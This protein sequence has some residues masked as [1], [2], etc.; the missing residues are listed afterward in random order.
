MQNWAL[1][2][3]FILFCIFISYIGVIFFNNPIFSVLSLILVF[4]FNSILFL[5]L[6]S[7]FLAVII[8]IIYVGAISILF[9][10]VIMMFDIRFFELEN[11]FFKIPPLSFFFSIF[12]ISI[13]L[14]FNDLVIFEIFYLNFS[15]FLEIYNWFFIFFFENNVIS[16]GVFLFNYFSLSIILL[17]IILLLSMVGCITLVGN[18]NFREK[19]RIFN[20]INIKFPFSLKISFWS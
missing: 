13:F 11:F 4:I 14:F 18:F 1:I 2:Y 10:F 12:F 17:G 19:Q 5:I 9:L 16:L 6:G 20:D 7:D 3:Y 15:F 8:L